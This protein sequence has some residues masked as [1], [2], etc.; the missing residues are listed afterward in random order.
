MH[1]AQV[2][3]NRNHQ[4]FGI[5]KV[6]FKT[7]AARV[8]FENLYPRQLD[9]VMPLL[10]RLKPEQGKDVPAKIR[11]NALGQLTV[12]TGYKKPYGCELIIAD[13]SYKEPNAISA[14]FRFVQK[15]GEVREKR[16]LKRMAA[17]QAKETAGKVDYR[18]A[19]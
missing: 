2:N 5:T 12:E 7:P 15:V 4:S 13:K 14:L 8:L 11:R 9:E 18:Q 10:S 16:H 17:K 19:G 6:E 1:I 3:N